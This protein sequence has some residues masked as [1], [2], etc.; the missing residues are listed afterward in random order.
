VTR[1]PGRREFLLRSGLLAGTV[2]LPRIGFGESA[3]DDSTP[4]SSSIFFQT[5][6]PKVQS[7]YQSALDLLAAN[8][9]TLP[10]WRRPVLIEGSVYRGIWLECAPQEGLVYSAIRPE[11]ARNNH[12]AFFELQREDGQIPCNVG[13]NDVGHGQIQMVVPIAATAWELSQ[14]TGDSEL[15]EAAY[16]SCGRWDE[17]LRRYRDTRHAGLCE[18][19]CTYD[20]GHDNSPRWAGIPNGCPDGDARKCPPVPSLPRLCPDLSAT[21]YG[22]RVALAAMAR[23]LGKSSE[24][25]QW[26]ELAAAIRTLI[27]DRLYDASD[28]AFYDLD[29]QDHF[30]RVR[31]DLISRVLS[32]HVVDQELFEAIYRKQIHNPSA[33]WAPYPLPSIALDDPHF[34]RP[35]P[36]NSWGGA[37]QALTALRTPR[38]LEHYGKQADLAH[39]MQQWVDALLRAADFRQ[40]L[41]PLTGVFTG[42]APGYSPAALVLIDFT[43]RLA[44]VRKIGDHLEWNVRPPDPHTRSGFRLRV[45]PTLVAEMKYESGHAELLLNNRR[46]FNTGST[47]RLITTQ[48]G[49]L[50]SAGG[51]ASQKSPVVLHEAGG[52]ERK[53]SIEPNSNLKF[54]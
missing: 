5:N 16:R 20:S 50:L 30:V 52:S 27:M 18:G 49:A 9:Q 45:N 6:D 4:N 12:L 44:G 46:R 19:F 17:W 47:V 14:Q 25:D 23:A 37:S 26:L 42:D 43:W 38:W 48:G 2:L 1:I 21:V 31:G 35:I 54:Q 32:E 28:S 33:F 51:I 15:L 10:V 11:I 3:T 41:D 29:A 8:V 22:G 24:A 7:C 13:A 34:V 40:Q 36:R 39:L 53:F